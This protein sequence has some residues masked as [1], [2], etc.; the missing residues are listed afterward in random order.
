MNEYACMGAR[1]KALR[2]FW[3]LRRISEAPAGLAQN[4][5]DPSRSLYGATV[6]DCAPAVASV[7]EFLS[8]TGRSDGWRPGGTAAGME[9]SNRSR[10]CVPCQTQPGPGFRRH[11]KDHLVTRPVHHRSSVQAFKHIRNKLTPETAW[12][13]ERTAYDQLAALANDEQWRRNPPDRHRD[14]SVHAMH[15][16]HPRS[17]PFT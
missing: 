1:R 2:E 13:I 16:Q 15:H 4:A 12:Y 8:R 9:F 10:K 7:F 17:N 14:P 5:R 6:R 3:H 11:A